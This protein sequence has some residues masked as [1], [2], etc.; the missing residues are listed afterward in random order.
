[1]VTVREGEWSQRGMGSGHSEGEGVHG[2]I[3]RFLAI[4]SAGV[5][6]QWNLSNQDISYH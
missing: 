4:I 2:H 5:S 6:I 3:R 1:M